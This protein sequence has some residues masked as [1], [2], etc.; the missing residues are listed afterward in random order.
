MHKCFAGGDT[1]REIPR[2]RKKAVAQA[3]IGCGTDDGVLADG[4]DAHG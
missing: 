1:L 2:K 4:V 3:G